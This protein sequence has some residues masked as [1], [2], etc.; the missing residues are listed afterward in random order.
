MSKLDDIDKLSFSVKLGQAV[1]EELKSELPKH[2]TKL[3]QTMTDINL[4]AVISGTQTV[5]RDVLGKPNE[6]VTLDVS[7][8]KR[9]QWMREKRTDVQIVP[10][11]HAPTDLQISMAGQ[12]LVNMESELGGKKARNDDLSKLTEHKGAPTASVMAW[13][14]QSFKHIDRGISHLKEESKGREEP[15]VAVVQH[16]PHNKPISE[17]TPIVAVVNKGEVVWDSRN[18]TAG[19]GTED[20]WTLV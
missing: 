11:Q 9:N 17:T 19:S 18:P 5:V 2:E 15:Y 20:G 10:P 7:A 8:D 3:A 13:R 4:N 6:T 16:W 1:H 14:E 12:F